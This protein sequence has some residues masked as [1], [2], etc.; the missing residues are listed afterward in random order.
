MERLLFNEDEQQILE[1]LIL[2]AEN[3]E[4]IG[5]FRASRLLKKVNSNSI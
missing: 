4:L 1:K 2:N 3:E 5:I